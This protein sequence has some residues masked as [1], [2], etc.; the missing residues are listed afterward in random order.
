MVYAQ[1]LGSAAAER[2]R[3]R[4]LEPLVGFDL[5]NNLI[6]RGQVKC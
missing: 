3:G 2:K 4:P 1:R 6:S 5:D